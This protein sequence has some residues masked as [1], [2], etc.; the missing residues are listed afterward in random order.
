M[1]NEKKGLFGRLIG[2]K[3]AQK[4][5]CCCNFE[6]EEITEENNK[7]EEGIQKESDGKSC[8]Q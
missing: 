6:V 2:N 8:C 5:P 3:K 4:K 7:K 1:E